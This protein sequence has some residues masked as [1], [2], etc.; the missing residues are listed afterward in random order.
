MRVTNSLLSSQ[1]MQNL[2]KAMQRLEEQQNLITTGKRVGKPSDDPIDAAKIV[3][4]KARYSKQTQ[5]GKN[6]ASAL[7]WMNTTSS[8]LEKVIDILDEVD[9]LINTLGDPTTSA[10]RENAAVE[11]DMLLKGLLSE[12]NRKLMGKYVFGG[13]ETLTAPFI[14][15]YSGDEVISVDQNP[16]GID[17]T[18]SLRLSD[19]DTIT[20]NLPGDRVFQPSGAGGD[21]DVFK[22]LLDLRT[23]LETNDSDG[24]KDVQQKL[25]DAI[26]RIASENASSGGSIRRLEDLQLRLEDSALLT[27][28]QR[29]RL[30][31]ADIAKAMLDY[32]QAELTYEAALAATSRVIQISLVNFL[33]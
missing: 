9:G 14:A 3:G 11:V 19:V 23:A 29:S 16:D 20:L 15:N 17:G 33:K 7:D 22:L 8:T 4:V 5:Y 12:A 26:K 28:E 32:S 2:Q 25:D 13:N 10:E 27:D 18:R 30:E 31:D 6:I 24:M 21:D 1:A